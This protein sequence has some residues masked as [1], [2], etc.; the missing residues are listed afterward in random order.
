MIKSSNSMTASPVS[1]ASSAT[2]TTAPSIS[3]SNNHTQVSVTVNFNILSQMNIWE[4][5]F[6]SMMI[7]NLKRKYDVRNGGGN[8]GVNVDVVMPVPSSNFNN[9]QQRTIDHHHQSS[10]PRG[11]QT[12]VSVNI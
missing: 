5:L 2:M 7:K 11:I 9:S 1:F 8:M 4:F 12:G 6:P 3:V 10:V